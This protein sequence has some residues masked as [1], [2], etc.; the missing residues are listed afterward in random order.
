MSVFDN[1]KPL[2]KVSEEPNIYIHETDQNTKQV[3]E[4][5]PEKRSFNF[6]IILVSILFIL[7]MGK[8]ATLQITQGQ[9]NL[10]LANGNRIRTE[11]ITAPRGLILDDT[12]EPLL[13]N[14]ARYDVNI[15]PTNLPKNKDQRDEAYKKVAAILGINIDKYITEVNKVG[16]YSLEPITIESN[17]STEDSLKYQVEL[18]DISGIEVSQAPVRSY[19]SGSGWGHILGYIAKISQQELASTS[20]AQATDWVG[21]AGLEEQY[22]DYLKGKNGHNELEINAQGQ[23]QR[24]V[25]TT[26][27]IQGNNLYLNIDSKLQV[28][29]YNALEQQIQADHENKVTKGVAIAFNPNDGSIYSYVSY[30]DYDPN[31]F[32]KGDNKAITAALTDSN[33]VLLNRGIAGM[34]PPGSTIKPTYATAALEEKT[35]SP[36]TSFDTP[37]YINVGSFKFP[38]WKN[39]SGKLTDV[40]TAI[41]ESNDIFFYAVAGGYGPIKGLGIDTIDKYLNQFGFGAKTGIDLPG[42]KTGLVPTAAWKKK[43]QG[44]SWYIG[45]NY[46]VGIGQGALTVTPIQLV[47]DLSAIINGGTLVTPHLGKEIKTVDGKLVKKINPAPRATNIANPDDLQVVRAGMRQTVEAG[48]AQNLKN[49]KGLNGQDIQAAGKTGTAQAGA[50]NE[51]AHAWFV[52]YAP[53]DN[54]KV[55]VVVLIE[56]GEDSYAYANPVAGQIFQNFFRDDNPNAK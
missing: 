34:Y 20:N 17:I 33:Q 11:S 25:S 39:H 8:L 26:Q 2:G 16:L 29:T 51:N 53:Y 49:L 45:D 18:K 13:K 55:G 54:P 19:N 38:D 30:P 23:V 47:S 14:V 43:T 22:Q 24:I 40:K 50:N 37:P 35:I 5:E 15:I 6:F 10:G 32:I 3:I 31:I 12:G 27:P 48:S 56:D 1:Y 7:L 28:A 46:H 52:G 42:E 4:D 21:R 9:Y 41:A 36:S 44:E